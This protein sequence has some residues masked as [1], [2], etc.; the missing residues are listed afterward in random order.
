MTYYK[1][2][3]YELSISS[4]LIFNISLSSVIVPDKRKIARVVPIR[5]KENKGN[6]TNN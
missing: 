1:K 3:K 5:N 4:N 6:I 2:L